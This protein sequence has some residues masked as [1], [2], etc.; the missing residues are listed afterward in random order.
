MAWHNYC[1]FFLKKFMKQ[2]FNQD[3]LD[4]LIRPYIENTVNEILPAC[5]KRMLND[6]QLNTKPEAPMKV[7]ETAALLGYSTSH[8]YTLVSKNQIPFH[9][10]AS[11]RV[12]FYLS[13]LNEHIRTVK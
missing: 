13:E 10:L 2:P 3:L 12:M 9:K 6:I 8:L 11:G 5:L 4:A 1:P 7:K